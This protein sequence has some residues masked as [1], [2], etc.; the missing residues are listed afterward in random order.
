MTQTK[1]KGALAAADARTRSSIADW[2]R[3][4][5]DL[6]GAAIAQ[7]ESRIGREFEAAIRALAQVRGQVL[8]LGVGKSGLVAKK[9]AATL[10]STGTPATFVHPVDAVH[11][12]LGIVS[13][14]DAALLLSKSGETRELLD[15]IPAFR[16]RGVT[17]IA[18]TGNPASS[19]ALGADHV[20]DIGTP[21]EAC[22]EDL[23]PTS[24][25]TAMLALGDA[26][27]VVLLRLKGFTRDDFAVLHPGGVLGRTASL[28]VFDLMHRGDGLPRVPEGAALRQALLEI[29]NK[30]LGMTTVVDASGRLAGILTDGDLK[31][32]LLRG[33]TD[34]A[35][36]VAAVMTR[37]PRL[38][39]ADATIA[40]AVR[41]MEENEGGPITSLVVLDEAGAPA[42]VL[43][44]HDC[45]G[46]RAG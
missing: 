24:S 1:D 44:L 46:V 28:R 43:H 17:V 31:R 2:A 41:T 3:E 34:L 10:T 15:L 32:I 29:L 39:E 18:M 16:R 38:I 20:L 5:L 26:V 27:A 6:E 37:S 12:D 4:V 14:D 36:P 35:Q 25:T 7:L 21:R 13:A 42:G 9:I 23:V 40:R 11:G 19:L 45:L 30:R 22:G 33:G 8:T